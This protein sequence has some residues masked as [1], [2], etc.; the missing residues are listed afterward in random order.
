MPRR[1]KAQAV[2][3]QLLINYS[4]RMS[5]F[6]NGKSSLDTYYIIAVCLSSSL[7]II[8]ADLLNVST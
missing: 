5:P 3:L 6:M 7:A 8:D 2:A 1:D 4:R